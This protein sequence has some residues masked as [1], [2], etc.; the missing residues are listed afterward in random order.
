M[1]LS[2]LASFARTQSR[3]ACAAW[4]LAVS[5]LLGFDPP[6]ILVYLD[7]QDGVNGVAETVAR[8]ACPYLRAEEVPLP[9]PF[10]VRWFR[11]DG[12]S[13]RYVPDPGRRVTGLLTTCPEPTPVPHGL[14]V[15]HP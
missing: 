11:K 9:V 14:P 10:E 6:H 3:H 5:V 2:C 12:E 15:G 7:P 8:E 1:T 13:R 4:V